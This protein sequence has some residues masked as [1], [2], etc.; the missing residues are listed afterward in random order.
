MFALHPHHQKGISY[1][2]SRNM[3]RGAKRRLL[4]TI[5]FLHFFSGTFGCMM[6]GAKCFA[7]FFSFFSGVAFSSPLFSE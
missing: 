5:F 4:Y 7:V 3:K 6:E 1:S 2:V